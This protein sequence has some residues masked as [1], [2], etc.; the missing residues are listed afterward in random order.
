MRSTMPNRSKVLRASRSRV[1]PSSTSLGPK[2]SSILRSICQDFL[3]SDKNILCDR[4]NDRERVP[5]RIKRLGRER[6]IAVRFDPSPGK[7]S[8]SALYYGGRRTTLKDLRK[9]ISPG[10]LRDMLVQL[11]L[12]RRDLE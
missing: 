11:G 8:H 4:L 12:T 10:L 1:S 7:G 9:E 6:D 2:A 3:P 5:G